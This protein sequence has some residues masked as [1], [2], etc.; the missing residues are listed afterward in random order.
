[1]RL[2]RAEWSRLFARRFTRTMILL[3]LGVLIALGLAVAAQSRPITAADHAR[4]R[5]QVAEQLRFVEQARAECEAARARGENVQQKYPPDCNFDVQGLDEAAFLP[6]Q[7]QFRRELSNFLF[8]AA[9]VLALFGFVVGASFI[10]AEWTSGGMTN[11]LLWRPRRLVVLGTKLVTMLT[12]VALVSAL[13]VAA[14]VG[15]L[16]LV[17]RYRGTTGTLTRGFWESIGLTGGRIVALTV[18]AA[19]AGFAIAS[20]GRHTAMALGVGIGYALVIEIGSLIV[21]GSLGLRDPQR[22]R[23]STYVFAWLAK[24]YE[25][26]VFNGPTCGPSGCAELKPYVVTWGTSAG[27]LGAVLVVLL[28]LAFVSTRRR[29]VT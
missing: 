2:V 8:L 1:M 3:I 16:W 20:L 17:G 27:V 5:A 18:V 14:F 11:L 24:R 23:L 28:M 22:W 13:Y 25:L 4:A 7:F 12:G 6:Y 9:G 26:P 21:F 10:G 19:A 29:D 15:A